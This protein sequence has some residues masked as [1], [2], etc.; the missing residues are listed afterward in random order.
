MVIALAYVL[1]QHRRCCGCSRCRAAA[2]GKQRRRRIRVGVCIC[3]YV[4]MCVCV[5]VCMCVCELSHVWYA[6]TYLCFHTQRL[7]MCLPRRFL[8]LSHVHIC[9]SFSLSVSLS[10]SLSI[11]F[12]NSFRSNRAAPI[13]SRGMILSSSVALL[14]GDG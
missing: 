13:S 7:G 10:C 14:V 2:R 9:L 1:C 6:Y 8:S 12:V 4:C 11:F 5:Y 3:V